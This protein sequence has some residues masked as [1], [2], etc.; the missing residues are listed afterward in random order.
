VS[1]QPFLLRLFGVPRLLDPRGQ[2][3]RLRTQKQLALLVYLALE[4]RSRPVARD[5]L[6]DLLWSDVDRRRSRHSLAQ[7]VT[8]IRGLLGPASMS[9]G[10]N[11]VQLLAGLVTDLDRLGGDFEG[12]TDAPPLAGVET[13]A[14]SELAHWV[15]AARARCVR[16]TVE[17]L[18]RALADL[19]STGEIGRLV[20]CATALRSLDPLSNVAVLTLAEGLLVRGD[21]VGAIRMLRDHVARVT[22][23]LACKPHPD[24]AVLLR[25]LEAGAHPPVETVPARLAAEA[26]RIRPPIFVGRA[27]ELAQLEAEWEEARRGEL[28]TCLV[29]GPG[30]IGKSSLLRR[31]ATG[32]AA[33]AHP[34]FMVTCQEI[35]QGI[36]FAAVADLINALARDP[37]LGATDPMWLAEATRIDPALKAMYPGIPDPPP[38]PAESIRIRV[39]EALFHMVRAVADNGPVAVLIDDVQ[40]MDPASRDVFH[41]LGKR[42]DRESLLL[43]G[44]TG[45]EQAVHARAFPEVRMLPWHSSFELPPLNAESTDALLR[46]LS[47]SLSKR[48]SAVRTKINEMS[49]GNPHLAALLARDWES[50]GSSSLAATE[51]TEVK[52]AADWQVPV[53]LRQVFARLYEHVGQPLQEMLHVLAVA[54]RGLS[55]GEIASALDA[56]QREVEALLFSGLDQEILRLTEGEICFKNDTHRSYVY[57]AMSAER[58]RYYHLRLARALEHACPGSFRKRL[59]AGSHFLQAEMYLDAARL[60]TRAAEEAVLHGAPAEAE[61]AASALIRRAGASAGIRLTLVDSLLAQ[62]KYRRALNEVQGLSELDTTTYEHA[63]AKVLELQVR[64]RGNLLD[65]SGL[66][67]LS[68]HALRMARAA[69]RVSLLAEA[70]QAAA[71]VAAEQRDLPQL[72]EVQAIAE[73]VVRSDD[74]SGSSSALMTLGFCGLVLGK[75][76]DALDG[77]GRA[78]GLLRVGANYSHLRRSL[79]GLGIAFSADGQRQQAIVAFEDALQ[80]AD[81]LCEPALSAMTWANLAVL[82]HNYGDFGEAL[83]CS[84]QAIRLGE[85]G[86]ADRR[87]AAVYWIAAA[88]ALDLGDTLAATALLATADEALGD[89]PSPRQVEEAALLRADYF[90]ATGEPERAWPLIEGIPATGHRRAY[91]LGEAARFERLTRHYTLVASGWDAYENLRS[92]REHETE[93]MPT[94]GRLE[95]TLFDLWV[96]LSTGDDVT[97][98]VDAAL[99]EVESRGLTG[100]VAQLIT[101]RVCPIPVEVLGSESSARQVARLFPRLAAHPIPERFDLP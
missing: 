92:S 35:G 93:R 89:S 60:V 13:W 97:P 21:V 38:A 2:L 79:N 68:R 77:F 54:A 78:V 17:T 75:R 65:E 6:I 4:G 71:E 53:S 50:R 28:R 100:I 82:H 67:S 74:P 46:V 22:D 91:M 70:A 9:R 64:T 52:P 90:L 37:G 26:H 7:A 101:S 44:T 11:G 1:A 81:R 59:E 86:S 69:G 27:P 15:D 34:V 42:L 87:A 5:V 56:A 61:L 29:T 14:G 99:S 12:I 36:P 96:R 10:G 30:G 39:A 18:L 72:L 40:Y 63:R 43:L 33:R 16:S 58:R 20:P 95:L 88:L 48:S 84:R 76:N 94:A 80:L 23:E 25:R 66:S 45:T 47:Q 57:Y 98:E 49:E 62:G 83:K 55:L 19:R 31:F 85:V 51:L 24:V 73:E 32:L 8:A 41:V 3:A